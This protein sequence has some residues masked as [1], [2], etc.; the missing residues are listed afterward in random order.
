MNCS[1]DSHQNYS[2]PSPG[3]EHS[4]LSYPSE[5]QSS[6]VVKSPEAIVFEPDLTEAAVLEILQFGKMEEIQRLP[7]SSNY[8]LLMVIELNN[9][10]LLAVYKPQRGESPLWD[11]ARGT[12]CLREVAAYAVD[13]ALR[14]SLIPPTVLRDG[15][16]G[17]GSVQL[18]IDHDETEHYFTLQADAHYAKEFQQMALFDF[19]TNNADRKS[20]HCLL[21]AGGRIWAIDHGICF[22]EEY[23]LR[24][25]VWEF[26]N[27]IIEAALLE[28]LS[29]LQ[30]H[31]H[32]PK[33]ELIAQLDKL[34]S[35]GEQTAMCQRLDVLLANRTYP[36]PS[37]HRRNMPWPPI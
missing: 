29:I 34:L 31:L 37:P 8:N 33:S 13:S 22:H 14:W 15:H 4:S 11:F 35:P 12:L 10:Q 16:H 1:S 28:D 17:L 3:S 21:D 20:G 25:V 26:S 24:T 9:V 6:P 18:F 7:Y 32:N 5:S 19:I 2:Q 36:A 27:G 30:G 23:K